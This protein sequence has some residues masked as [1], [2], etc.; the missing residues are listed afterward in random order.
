MV[1]NK[2]W[3]SKLKV[4][5]YL[6]TTYVTLKSTE[7]QA[8]APTVSI[9]SENIFVIRRSQNQIYCRKII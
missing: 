2:S 4:K 3:K 5:N 9:K 8:K 1:E 6:L 7:D